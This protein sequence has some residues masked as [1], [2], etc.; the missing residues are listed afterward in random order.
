MREASQLEITKD[1]LKVGD[2]VSWRGNFG[3]EPARTAKV[4]LIEITERP[5][6]CPGRGWDR[7]GNKYGS[8][9]T[10]VS[11]AAVREDRVVVTLDNG[12][13]AYGYQITQ[14]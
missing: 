5:G 2:T 9:A 12:H 7:S 14:G 6:N 10:E 3:M 11:W 1:I 8:R 13:W 4:T